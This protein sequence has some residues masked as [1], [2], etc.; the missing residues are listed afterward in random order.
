MARQP[1]GTDESVTLAQQL[2][3]QARTAEEL[4]AAQ[5]VLLPLLGYSLEATAAAI[6]KSRHWVSRTRN[7]ILRGEAPPARHGGR[8]RAILAE[9]EELRLVRAAI[10]QSEGWP[11]S[12][13]RLRPYL[14]AELDKQNGS[15]V[16]E[17]TLTA[18]LNRAAPHFLGIPGAR[19][20]DLDRASCFLARIW[21]A[22]SIIDDYMSRVDR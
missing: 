10:Q 22:Q 19:G 6:G 17:S 5:A 3:R 1:A 21:H 20:T 12:S 2:M 13:Q 11:A 8:R 9:T 15:P 14:R 16:S 4:R 18:V 7:S